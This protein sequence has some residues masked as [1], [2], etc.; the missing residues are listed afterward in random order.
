MMG[1]HGEVGPIFESRMRKGVW[2]AAAAVIAL[3]P[4]EQRHWLVFGASGFLCLL[5]GAFPEESTLRRFAEH[6]IDPHQAA[7]YL[8]V[9]SFFYGAVCL[10]ILAGLIAWL[11]GL[12]LPLHLPHL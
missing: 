7:P 6:G 11:L 9:I 2:V 3:A 4:A 12:N 5:E 8:F 10:E 1:A